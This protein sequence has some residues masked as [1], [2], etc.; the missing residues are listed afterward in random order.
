M[1]YSNGRTY[2]STKTNPYTVSQRPS[3]VEYY[4]GAVSIQA[5]D[6]DTNS[7]DR[8][9]YGILVD[10]GTGRITLLFGQHNPTASMGRFE[11]WRMATANDISSFEYKGLSSEFGDYCKP[12]FRS[13]DGNIICIGRR[14]PLSTS[15]DGNLY[16]SI[17]DND[18][19][20]STPVRLTEHESSPPVSGEPR[21]YP[22]CLQGHDYYPGHEWSYFFFSRRLGETFNVP[23]NH[24]YREHMCFKFRKDNPYVIYNLAE[25]FNKDV[26][27]NG[28]ITWAE[29]SANYVYL[30]NTVEHGANS[31]GIIENGI[32]RSNIQ[33]QGAT[34]F[35]YYN[36]SSWSNPATYT[37]YTNVADVNNGVYDDAVNVYLSRLANTLLQS[38]NIIYVPVSG[39]WQV[40]I[41]MNFNQIPRGSKFAAAFG[42]LKNGDLSTVNNTNENDLIILEL[43]K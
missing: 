36:G 25:T 10:D 29:L 1:L 11:V 34:E 4:N 13:S 23:P 5:M 8:H 3:I 37:Q 9:D 21:Y 15:G 31:F 20:W 18:T 2:I 30:T 24:I 14:D 22:T 32:V 19:T 12:Y 16:M 35:L 39:V 33:Y 42:T 38:Q 28:F 43:Q 6:R 40:N 17:Y 7:W 41:P 26:L 27:T